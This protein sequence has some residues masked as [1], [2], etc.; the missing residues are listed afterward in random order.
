MDR[1]DGQL[2]AQ[3]REIPRCCAAGFEDGRRDHESRNTGGTRL[4]SG[5]R[6]EMA[7]H[8]EPPEVR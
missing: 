1:G 5:N 7:S 8:L 4:E 3:I 2:E 6:K